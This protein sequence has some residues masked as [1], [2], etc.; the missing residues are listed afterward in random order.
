M[1]NIVMAI[2]VLT[3]IPAAAQIPQ[4]VEVKSNDFVSIWEDPVYIIALVGFLALMAVYYIYRRNVVKKQQEK[5][6]E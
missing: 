5:D 4:E 3:A 6:A 1:R 2:T